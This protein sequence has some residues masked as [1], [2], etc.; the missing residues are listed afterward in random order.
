[1]PFALMQLFWYML[2]LPTTLNWFWEPCQKGDELE[3]SFM[4]MLAVQFKVLQHM[5]KV[6]VRLDEVLVGIEGNE[7]ILGQEL[8]VHIPIVFRKGD[9]QLISKGK[10]SRQLETLLGAIYKSMK[11]AMGIDVRMVGDCH[12]V[13]VFHRKGWEQDVP[14]VGSKRGNEG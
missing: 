10:I 2:E 4:E 5:G 11:N 12:K 3:D 14:Y 1:M 13:C 8:C 7:A 6:K 9:A